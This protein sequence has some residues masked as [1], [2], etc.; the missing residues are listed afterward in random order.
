MLFFVSPLI[1][2]R[3]R[4]IKTTKVYQDVHVMIWIGFRYLMTFLKRYGQGAV[5]LTFLMSAVLVQVALICE[6]V[7]HFDKN[8][9]AYLSL[10]SL[11]GANVAVAAPLISMGALL[12]KTTYMQLVFMGITELIIY[13]IN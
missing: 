5:G 13:T 12:G 9:K 11:L 1:L 8:N 6:G 10:A 3:F 2:S 7:L 4:P